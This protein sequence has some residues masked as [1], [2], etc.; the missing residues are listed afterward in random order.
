[1]TNKEKLEAFIRTHKRPSTTDT[2]AAYFMLSRRTVNRVMGELE[3]ENKVIKSKAKTNRN[4]WSWN[5]S[6]AVPKPSAP[7]QPKREPAPVVGRPTAPTPSYAH[8]RG[9]DD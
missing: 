1:M 3:S 4:I 5:H 7:V 8:I 2:L 9:Y 6:L